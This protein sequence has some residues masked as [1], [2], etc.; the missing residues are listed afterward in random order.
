MHLITSIPGHK[1]RVESITLQ[2]LVRKS[3]S[4]SSHHRKQHH[5]ILSSL[6]FRTACASLDGMWLAR[7][8]KIHTILITLITIVATSHRNQLKQKSRGAAEL[9]F[10]YFFVGVYKE[11]FSKTIQSTGF[12]DQ[13]SEDDNK[14]WKEETGQDVLGYFNRS[15]LTYIGKPA[16]KMLRFVLHNRRVFN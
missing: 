16:I 3:I 8:N 10:Y 15:L 12:F 6:F 14:T 13:L 2:K 5:S 7:N 4:F 11:Q 1:W 9:L